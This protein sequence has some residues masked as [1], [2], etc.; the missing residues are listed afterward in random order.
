LISTSTTFTMS[1]IYD[2][3]LKIHSEKL[4]KLLTDLMPNI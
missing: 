2:A 1:D 3:I 4:R